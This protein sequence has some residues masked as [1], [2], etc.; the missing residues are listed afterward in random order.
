MTNERIN[1][2]VRMTNDP[3]DASALTR[4]KLDSSSFEFVSDFVIRISSF[5]L[6]STENEKE[7]RYLNVQIQNRV[8]AW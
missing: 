8:D 7:A 3:A 1:S 2:E 6:R 5:R 4:R